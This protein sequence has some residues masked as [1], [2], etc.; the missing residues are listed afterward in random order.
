M[1]IGML[2]QRVLSDGST[3]LEA[4]E[5][6]AVLHDGRG[7]PEAGDKLKITF[8]T[9]CN[10]YVYIIGIDATGYVAEIFPDPDT[11]TGNPV[12]A[13]RKYTL[14]EG[15][16]WWGLDE[17]KGIESVYFIASVGRR[18]DIEDI[19]A[20]LVKMK[21]DVPTNDYVPVKTAAVIQ[22]TRGLIKVHAGQPVKVTTESGISQDVI[23][24]AFTTTR[25]D[26][27]LI[28]TGWFRHE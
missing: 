16:L 4:I 23:P 22:T 24:T 1:D 8:R 28:I 15:G 6:G 13:D 21:R 10:C 18:A 5:N 25:T 20:R 14:P 9:N 27:D 7:N 2:A 11:A 12:T 26:T 17:Y 19:V 3:V